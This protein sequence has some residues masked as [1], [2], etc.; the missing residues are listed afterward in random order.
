MN[1]RLN[2]IEQSE[3]TLVKK[4][5]VGVWFFQHCIQFFIL[6]WLEQADSYGYHDGVMSYANG[7]LFSYQSTLDFRALYV[8]LIFMTSRMLCVLCSMLCVMHAPKS[9]GLQIGLQCVHFM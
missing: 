3:T 9:P 7:D 4:L 8:A 6:V 5:D 1:E 2:V